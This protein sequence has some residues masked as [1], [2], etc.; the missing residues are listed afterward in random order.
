MALKYLVDL[1]INDNVLQNARVLSSGSA[2]TALIGAIYVDTND[3]NKLKYHDG[4][5]FI[6]LGSATGDLTA[7][8][9]GAGLTGTSLSGPVPTLNVGAGTG[10]TINADDIAVTPAQTG[11]TSIYNTDLVIGG[12]SGVNSISFEAGKIAFVSGSANVA[13]MSSNYFRPTTDNAIKLGDSTRRWSEMRAVNI[14]G[15][16]TGN[17]S[18]A[19]TLA[20]ARTIGGVSF[21]GSANINLPGVNT[22]GNQATSGNAASATVLQ[23]ARAINGVNFNGSAAIT[24]TAA[25]STLSD[26]VPISKGGTGA[27]SAGSALSNF[28]GTDIGKSVFG[29]TNPSAVTFPRFNANNTTT[30][31]TASAFRAAIGAG[32]GAG[33]ITAVNTNAGSGLSGGASSGAANLVIKNVDN[34]TD[35]TIMVWNDTSGN[36]EDSLITDNGS[37]VVINGNLD[38]QGTTTTID[39][40]TVAIGDNMMKYAKDNTANASDIG[41]YGKIVASGTKYPGMFYDASSGVSTP[42]F[43]VGLS[44][45]EPGGTATIATKGT[46]DANLTGSVTGNVTGNVTGS[47]GSTTGNAATA[48]ALQTARNIGG[49]SFNGTASINLPGVNQGGNQDT[50]GNAASA[51]VLETA[52]TIGGVSFN[53]SANINLPGVNAAGNQST[54]GNAATATALATGRTIRT[55]LASTSAPSFNGTANITPGVTGT[56]PVANGG[57]GLTSLS[58]FVRTTG[59]QTI[60]GTKTFSSTIGGNISGNAATATALATGRTIGMTGDVVWTSASFNGSGNVTGTSTIQSGAIDQSMLSNAVKGFEGLLNSGTSGIAR[61]YNTTTT[62]MTTFVLT[63]STVMGGG[64]GRKCMVEL[65]EAST[66]A[67]VIADVTRSST[68]VVVKM[69][70]NVADSAYGVYI[71]QVG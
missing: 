36:F 4:T 17:A 47:S 14:Y 23:T 26:T 25:G 6:S 35:N 21:D 27:T 64:D 20:T 60:A 1:N 37:T 63:L 45:T 44:T 19:T 50:S 10:M 57:T 34:F 51:T 8:V 33:D 22:A 9:A 40:T 65:R 70:G 12:A 29:L 32:T 38:V 2:P 55:N 5:Q 11:I 68:T 53:G 43:K 61:D 41:W 48:T 30:A 59:N 56:L 62:G 67:T 3:S 49:V 71:K 58:T 7:I 28:G 13:A 66:Y 69:K 31:L 16:L 46:V 42:V 24:I 15:A 18:T 54:T 39:S 52:R